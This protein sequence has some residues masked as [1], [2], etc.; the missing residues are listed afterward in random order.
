MEAVDKISVGV[1]K[2][3]AGQNTQEA[4]TENADGMKVSLGEKICY[5]VGDIGANL[6]WTTV[7]SFL[8]IYCTDVAG[9]AAGVVGTLML[10]ARLFD[11][12]SDLFMGIII[13]KTNTRWG[14]ARPWVLW[15][16]P[17]LVI[18]LIMIFTVPDLGANGKAIYLLLVYIFLAAV[19][20]TASNL[21]YNTMLSLVT[22][23]QHDRN[24]MNT[25]RFEF[26]MIAQLVINVI[27]IPLVHFLGNGQRGWTCMS[28]VYAIVAL[29]MFITT[30]A[31]TKERYK[32]IKKETT[33][34]KKTHPLKTIKILCRNKYF[35]LITLAFAVIYTSLGLTGGS[36]IYYAKYVFTKRFGKIKAL[37]VGFLFY[38]AG[39][40]L[41]IA[42][43]VNLPMIYTGLV[44]QGIGHAALYSCLFAIVGD[45]VDYSEWKDGIR[46]EGITYSVTSFGQKIGTGLGTAAL[47]WILAAGHYDGTAAVQSASA[48]FAIKGLFLYLPLVI[49][50]IVLII[51]YLFMGIDKIYPT[52]R[53]ELDERREKA[54]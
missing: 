25:I 22:T 20:F 45:V 4:I 15:S 14:K 46:E 6:V 19:C 27:T 32:P 29:G 41:E 53:K 26:T 36:R 13:D 16:A 51:W 40:V 8:T 33:A 31:G 10:I 21:S 12:V 30:F 11:G 44:L 17:P 3:K 39:L 50:V 23:E 47:G 18:S 24:V 7:A 1:S 43:P 5:G 34:K 42:G 37:F 52:V 35:I 48:I 28:I 49:T 38:A 54:E 9:I 2:E